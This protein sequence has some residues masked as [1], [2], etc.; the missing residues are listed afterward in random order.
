MYYIIYK[1]SNKTL[2]QIHIY[3]SLAE[4]NSDWLPKFEEYCQENDIAIL[5]TGA[6]TELIPLGEDEVAFKVCE[7]KSFGSWDTQT[8]NSKEELKHFLSRQL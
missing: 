7:V 5:R 4:F 2:N 6:K 1:L 8:F 3:N